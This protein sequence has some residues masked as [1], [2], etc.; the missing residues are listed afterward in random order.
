MA[1]SVRA[2]AARKEQRAAWRA[3]KDAAKKLDDAGRKPGSMNFH[4]PRP[5][6]GVIR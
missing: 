4:T 3:L 1:D 5:V 6:R 2:I